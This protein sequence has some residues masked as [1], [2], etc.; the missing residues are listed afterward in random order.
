MS[1]KKWLFSSVD[2]IAPDVHISIKYNV[3]LVTD[4][5]QK[6]QKIEYEENGALRVKFTTIWLLL[7]LATTAS[8]KHYPIA[9]KNTFIN[10]DLGEDVFTDQ[11]DGIVDCEYSNPVCKLLK[12]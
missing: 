1:R 8:I 4:G 3:C 2:S 6:V 7:A 10:E 5:F 11:P 9:A 12:D